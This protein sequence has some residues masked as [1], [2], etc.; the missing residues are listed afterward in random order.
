M[1]GMASEF[2]MAL[3]SYKQ[4]SDD[5]LSFIL[6]KGG[7]S[8]KSPLRKKRCQKVTPPTIAGRSGTSS[9]MEGITGRLFGASP[10]TESADE[11]EKADEKFE[12]R[13]STFFVV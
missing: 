11:D 2:G 8:G 10:E 1:Q 3:A 13:L 4:E 5:K 9:G 12:V 6:E 7:I